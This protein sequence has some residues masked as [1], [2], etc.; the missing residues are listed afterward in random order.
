MKALRKEAAFLSG[1]ATTAAFMLFGD[2]MMAD[3]NNVA[4]SSALFVWL[5]L[6]MM[7]CA[8]GVVRHADAL[9]ELLG[10][11]YGT[12]I[13]TLS[14]ISIE[15]ALIA[16][17]MLTGDSDPTLG[18][19]TMFAILMIVLNGMVGVVLLVGGIRHAEQDY[20]LR[21]ARSFMAVIV[22]LS[23]I[24]LVLPDFTTSTPGPTLSTFQAVF[25][26]AITAL[27]YIVFLG[28]QTV[29]HRGYFVQPS[30]SGEGE[31]DH[32][33]HASGSIAFHAVLLFLT[34]LPIVLLSKKLAALVEFGIDALAAPTALGGLLVAILVLTPEGL[35]A[36]NAALANRLQRSVNI[37]LG[38]SV[39]TIGLTVPAVVVISLITGH[40]VTLGL[41][42]AN[43]V[44]LVL[45]L[46]V[47]A[48]TFGGVRTNVLQG[49]VHLVLFFVYLVLIFQP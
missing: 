14:V 49:A 31:D 24:A 33:G 41:S 34:L 10:E 32:G 2:Q 27:L 13:L 37:C 36:V 23:V 28:I 39:S 29:R 4:L 44:L 16:A 38:S 26:A 47:S 6:V 3:L 20:N 18:R 48:L 7:W 22:P 43:M 17:I 5:F 45:T 42:G 8:F 11:P 35:A 1:A 46:F 15:V 25:F 40:A 12:L 9:A 21:G 30:G 19:D